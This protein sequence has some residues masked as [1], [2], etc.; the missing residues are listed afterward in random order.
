MARPASPA[1][2]TT[3]SMETDSP[4]LVVAKRLLDQAKLHGFRFQ[5]TAPG[6]DA[7]LVGHRTSSSW[8]DLIYIEGF[9][10]GCFAWR[11]RET[12]LILPDG[13]LIERQVDG[14]AID[15][16]NEVLAW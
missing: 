15:V 7:P 8:V 3:A 14:R 1:S 4:D 12:T 5:R 10:R 6:E 11:K 9:S 2:T 16:L 13:G